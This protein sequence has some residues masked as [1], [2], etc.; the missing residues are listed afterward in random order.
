MTK[1]VWVALLAMLLAFI[2]L[3]GCREDAKDQ[4]IIDELSKLDI[5]ATPAD[6]T[7]VRTSETKGGGSDVVAVRGASSVEIRYA[8]SMTP[9]QTWEWYSTQYATTWML[10]D[11]GR[12]A[13]DGRSLAGQQAADDQIYLTIDIYPSDSGAEAG[14]HVVLTVSKTRDD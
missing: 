14:S 12:P 3:A 4:K 1:R 11:N 5:L 6:A 9:D 2:P 8:S 13:A 10:Q 7:D